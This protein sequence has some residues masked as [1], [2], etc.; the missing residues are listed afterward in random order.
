MR[1]V[2][3]VT[4]AM[5]L[6]ARQALGSRRWW[7]AAAI[8]LAC[9]WL[10]DH[11]ALPALAGRS[12][13]RALADGGYPDARFE[14]EHVGLDRVRLRDVRLAAGIELGEVEL[15]VGVSALWGDRPAQ[16]TVRGARISLDAIKP[17]GGG[18]AAGRPPVDRVRVERAELTSGRDRVTVTG[19]IS[20]AGGLAVDLRATGARIGGHAVDEIV[21]RARA[22]GGGYDAAWE[23]RG[24]GW[25]AHGAGSLAWR[26][27]RL[28]LAHGRTELRARSLRAGDVWL[29]GVEVALDL[30]GPLD[31]LDVRGDA[32]ADRAGL[33]APAAALTLHDVRLPI[34]VRARHAGGALA[35]LGRAMVA[36]AGEAT[37]VAAGHRVRATELAIELGEAGGEERALIALGRGAAPPDRVRW[38]AAEIHGGGLSAEQLTGSYAFA[39]GTHAIAWRSSAARSLELGGG[40]LE[41]TAG[42][43]GGHVRL[44]RAR[45]EVAGGELTA[46]PAD[47][48]LA[49]GGAGPAELVIGARGLQ[50]GR[51]LPRRSVEATSVLDGELVLRLAGADAAFVRGQLHARGRGTIRVRDRELRTRA[52]AMSGLEQRVVGALADFEHTTLTAA[53]APR[54]GGPEL[55][56]TARGR[57]AHVPQELELSINVRG[58]W[59][60]LDR[61]ARS[62]R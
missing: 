26:A 45:L 22:A 3:D 61:L 8:V 53:L 51:L 43:E 28:G 48:A 18:G 14:V 12:V 27:G 6:A 57:G 35:V 9:S 38:S 11:H 15:D 62:H 32:R 16:A 29:E 33:A 58:V 30:A 5:P 47:L 41:V 56:L 60:A 25:T 37:L 4:A 24:A 19:E 39:T 36:R 40:A 46:G 34:A 31:A 52:I 13:R 23:L 2:P 54:G 55:R 59:A 50:L 10:A 20:L 49:D 21:V 7:R 44:E 42:R 1:A 17:G